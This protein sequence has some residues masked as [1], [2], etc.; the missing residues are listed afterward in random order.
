M[1]LLLLLLLRC[2]DV[3]DSRRCC[4][5]CS[6]AAWKADKR[7][8]CMH[9]VDVYECMQY[10]GL[11]CFKRFVGSADA[12][13]GSCCLLA[14]LIDIVLRF[15]VEAIRWE[16]CKCVIKEYNAFFH[17]HC[18]YLMYPVSCFIQELR[19]NPHASCCLSIEIQAAGLQPR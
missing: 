9:S 12:D 4:H 17:Y 19:P 6:E 16:R 3:D 10:Y 2:S 14:C 1:K 5:C 11:S 15:P 8:P 18:M 7:H 13:A